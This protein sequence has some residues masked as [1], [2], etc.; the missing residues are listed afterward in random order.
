MT[1]MV[2]NRCF[3][4]KRNIDSSQTTS[5]PPS[6]FVPIYHGSS[7]TYK[8]QRLTESSSYSFRIQ[9]VSAAGEGSPSDTHTFTTSKAVPP[10]LRGTLGAGTCVCVRPAGSMGVMERHMLS[11]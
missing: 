7:H 6:R 10:P 3:V 8:V 5:L 9:A 11:M 1:K 2:T 4:A